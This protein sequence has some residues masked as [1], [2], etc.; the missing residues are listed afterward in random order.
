MF[1]DLVDAG[2]GWAELNDL[3]ADLRDKA[4]ITGAAAGGEFGFQPGF[5]ADGLL[6]GG[7]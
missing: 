2:V 1:I 4:A 6:R 3:W 7:H 5:V